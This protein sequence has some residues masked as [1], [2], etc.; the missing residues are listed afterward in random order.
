MKINNRDKALSLEDRTMGVGVCCENCKFCNKYFIYDDV[1]GENMY[2]DL[3]FLDRELKP[4]EDEWLLEML[5]SE[6]SPWFYDELSDDL[7]ELLK[8]PKSD[9]E[10]FLSDSPRFVRP[11]DMCNHYLPEYTARFEKP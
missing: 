11:N 7:R 4:E 8:L 1:E 5:Q 6:Q 3:C 2:I 9:K 10:V